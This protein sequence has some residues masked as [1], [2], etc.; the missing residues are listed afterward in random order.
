MAEIIGRDIEVGIANGSEATEAQHSIQKT[1]ANIFRGVEHAEDDTTRGSI[2]ASKGRRV[3]E[4]WLEGSIAGIIHADAVG[5]F[6][7]NLWGSVSSDG[8]TNGVSTHTFTLDDDHFHEPLSLWLKEGSDVFTGDSVQ[9]NSLEIT[10]GVDDY[11]RFSTELIGKDLEK[12]GTFTPSYQKEV[13]FIG[14]DVTVKMANTK[15]GLSA[16]GAM[17]AKS[18]TVSQNRNLERNHIFNNEYSPDSVFGPRFETEV[19]ITLNKIPGTTTYADLFEG[20]DEKYLRVTIEGSQ[21]ISSNS[22][23]VNP[24]LEYTFYKAQVTGRSK[25]D[26]ADALVEEEITIGCYLQD[27]GGDDDGKV[28]QVILV[29]N[30]EDYD[31]ITS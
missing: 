29:N 12:T 7:A 2:V 26:D 25:S 8:P 17:K 30:T 27:D 9:V 11:L 31:A 15:A 18:F 3:V 6:L 16:A 28:G 23:D 4:R 14:R 22:S 5:Y 21:D 19:S 10:A 20:D 13:D 1:T 24:K